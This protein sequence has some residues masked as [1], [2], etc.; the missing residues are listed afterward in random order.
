[1]TVENVALREEL[2]ALIKTPQ[3]ELPDYSADPIV[4]HRVG[5][6][7]TET[8]THATAP[9]KRRVSHRRG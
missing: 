4:Q 9:T 1:M 3:L 6:V 7:L 8:S 2:R 5:K